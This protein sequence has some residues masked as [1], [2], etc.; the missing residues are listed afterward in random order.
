MII[1]TLVHL[2]LDGTGHDI[3]PLL[4]FEIADESKLNDV[5]RV[6]RKKRKKRRRPNVRLAGVLISDTIPVGTDLQFMNGFISGGTT[7]IDILQCIVE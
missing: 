1:A 6:M 7:V 3:V 5:Q 2:I 4:N